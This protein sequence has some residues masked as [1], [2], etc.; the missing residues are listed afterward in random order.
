MTP[1]SSRQR[2]GLLRS[3]I[4]LFLGWAFLLSSTL[5]ATEQVTYLHTDISGSPIAATDA[6]G[7]VLWRESYR[8]YG[9][10]WLN[11]PASLP[12]DLW[13]HGKELDATGLQYFGARYY[14]PAVGRFTGIDP[15]GFQE[16]NLHSFNRYAYGNNN[17]V[18]YLD[19]DGR[20]GEIGF[21]VLS[22]TVGLHSL[23]GNLAA[24]RYA[25][26]A[27]DALG[28]VADVALT[29]VPAVPG[30]VGL[31][32]KASR[33]TENTI[34][35]TQGA[36]GLSSHGGS[37]S[38]SV[39]AAGGEVWT[40]TGKISQ[41]DFATYVNS[42]LYKGDVN[43]ISGVH[44]TPSGATIP[45]LDLFKADVARFG[46]MPGVHVHNFTDMTSKQMTNLLRGP[47]TTI[48]GFCDSG[49]C[50]APFK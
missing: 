2:P 30:A 8:G 14:D 13:F 27:V 1:D 38:S 12:Q 23:G 45:D 28:V 3:I 24:G 10:R 26:A 5:A 22:I 33:T 47:G 37:F 41:N 50:L 9:E 18:K 40:A 49:A 17:P 20:Y 16:G 46:S 48:G 25:A 43:I 34:S 19:P 31:G 7:N 15:V 6:T 44:G 32:I 42:G 4:I 21:E 11:Q 29:A 36:R 35:A 39:N